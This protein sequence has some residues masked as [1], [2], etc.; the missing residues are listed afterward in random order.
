MPQSEIPGSWSDWLISH[1]K[2]AGMANNRFSQMYS[3]PAHD[4]MLECLEDDVLS[5]RSILRNKDVRKKSI[6][7]SVLNVVL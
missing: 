4:L 2:L 6:C 7:H 1:L 5:P 3:L